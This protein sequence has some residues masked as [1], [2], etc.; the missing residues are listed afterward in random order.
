MRAALIAALA[1]AAAPLARAA[2]NIVTTKVRGIGYLG[3][4]VMLQQ[5]KFGDVNETADYFA[6]RQASKYWMTSAVYCLDTYCKNNFE[7]NYAQF[8]SNMYIYGPGPINPDPQVYR[9]MT[10]YS[11]IRKIDVQSKRVQAIIWNQTVI[12]TQLNFDNAYRTQLDFP[13][14]EVYDHAFG[15]GLYVL[16]GAIVL[17][18]MVNRVL[19]YFSHR[20][21]AADPEDAYAAVAADDAS[22]GARLNTWYRKHIGTP[23][24]FGYR[25]NQSVGW[26]WLSVPTRVQ[27]I[28]V[29]VYVALNF[30]FTFA[31]YDTFTDNLF[32]PG[33]RDMQ[34]W[35]Y[36][37]DRTGIMSFWNLPLLWAFAGRNDILIWL[38]GWSYSGCNLFH[39]WVA[40]VATIQAI[41]HSAAYTWFEIQQ[42]GT[43]ADMFAEQYW[44]TGVFATVTMSLL[45]PLSFKPIRA[46][47]YEVFLI[48]HIVLAAATLVLLFYHVKVMEGTY[49]AWLW[50]CVGIWAFDR[51]VRYIRIGALS[52]KAFLGKKNT[53]ARL[54]GSLDDG[55]LVRLT[56]QSSIKT[57]PAPGAY[58]FLYTPRSLTPWENHPFTLASSE[59]TAEGTQLNFL[60][61]PQAGATRKIAK[62]IAAAGS[63][64]TEMTVL[65]E[66][67][68][69]QVHPVGSYEHVL[70]VAGGSGITS[71]LPYVYQL[72]RAPRHPRKVT[73]VWAVRNATY[74]SDVLSHELAPANTAGIDVHVHV[75]REDGATASDVIDRLPG[76][77]ASLDD[78]SSD[79]AGDKD[80]DA[81]LVSKEA[82][83]NGAT[84]RVHSGR[85]VMR[86]L[87]DYHAAQ[88]L[89]AERLAILACGPGAML[90]DIR[91]AVADAYGTEEG[92]VR[93]DAIRYYEDAFGW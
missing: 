70:L 18:G 41:I 88:L 13:L 82:G 55:S 8:N 47:V 58:Y 78:T 46:K 81:A 14:T 72:A 68:Y 7:E 22:I 26:G 31:A 89:G 64:S 80:K 61:A 40:R 44:A 86:A 71:V 52:Y 93:G 12:G 50:A 17:V 66:G 30:I 35:R 53:V 23:A 11:D 20:A 4:Q 6:A 76:H 73:L 39:R 87:V 43:M 79:T 27:A 33:R 92:K 51:L 36:V 63:S 21:Q 69:G 90:D 3:C 91:A 85:A 38:T 60:F 67:P 16:L 9:D 2:E 24:A 62:R 65:V 84:L 45:I 28:G 37:A 42:E 77:I 25:H 15:W 34:L 49:D 74:A 83:K 29:F 10:N 32:Y 56:V 19:G 48:L 5:L 59:D 1:A 57:K 75:S 54:S